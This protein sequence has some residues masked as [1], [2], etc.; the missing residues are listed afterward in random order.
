MNH[1]INFCQRIDKSL[2]LFKGYKRDFVQYNPQ[3]GKG[4]TEEGFWGVIYIPES[5]VSILLL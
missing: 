1:L 3:A 5:A 4:R 2:K